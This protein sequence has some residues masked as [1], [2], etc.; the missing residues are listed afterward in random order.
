[1]RIYEILSIFVVFQTEHFNCALI[2]S[3]FF[4][5]FAFDT[6]ISLLRQ[7]IVLH[8]LHYAVY[9]FFNISAL[10]INTNNNVK[11]MKQ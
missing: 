7:Y 11:I 4:F 10:A 6:V 9:H 3:S 5:F 1:M 2:F 8:F